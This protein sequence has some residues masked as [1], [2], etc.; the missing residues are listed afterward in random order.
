MPGTSGILSPFTDMKSL[1]FDSSDE[2]DQFIFDFMTDINKKLESEGI[3]CVQVQFTDK[4]D[5]YRIM[6]HA[7]E[8]SENNFKVYGVS[9]DSPEIIFE[10]EE[11]VIAE[12]EIEPEV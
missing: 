3:E 9:K 5:Y 6:N 4:D 10:K 1:Y 11:D 2:P 12:H 7:R 8:F